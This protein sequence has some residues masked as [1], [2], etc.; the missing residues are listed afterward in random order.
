MQDDD[1]VLVD[2]E[3]EMEESE[4]EDDEEELTESARAI[5]DLQREFIQ[6]VQKVIE[7]LVESN[8]DHRASIEAAAEGVV[9]LI[10]GNG[11]D[12]GYILVK[13]TDAD[14]ATVPCSRSVYEEHLRDFADPTGLDISVG[15]AAMF[16]DVNN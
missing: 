14:L 7:P 4:E 9:S 11:L 6:G 8:P 10:E 15:L 2:P 5:E 13:R 12:E 1:V 16:N 3:L